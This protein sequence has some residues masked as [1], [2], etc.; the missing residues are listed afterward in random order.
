MSLY[1]FMHR[2]FWHFTYKVFYNVYLFAAW[3]PRR[4]KKGNLKSRCS[5]LFLRPIWKEG[6]GETSSVRLLR[7]FLFAA[8][9]SASLFHMV[10]VKAAKSFQ[11]GKD[12]ACGKEIAQVSYSQLQSPWNELWLA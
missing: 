5:E 8:A 4:W 11:R 9:S 2:T 10:E 1:F 3:N 7:S 6:L 12:P